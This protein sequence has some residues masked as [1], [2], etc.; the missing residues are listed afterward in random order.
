MLIIK[1][2]TDVSEMS[3]SEIWQSLRQWAESDK[4][5]ATLDE[6]ISAAGLFEGKE[7]PESECDFSIAGDRDMFTCDLVWKKSH[8]MLFTSS[9]EEDYQIARGSDW[10][11]IYCTDL[12]DP[13]DLANL[14]KG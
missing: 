11:C 10:N 1:S 9:N 8:V 13:R 3:Y 2:G 14:I 6:L 4:E 5:K 7:K 12:D